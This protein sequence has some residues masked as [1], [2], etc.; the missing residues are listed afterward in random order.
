MMNKKK[1]IISVVFFICYLLVMCGCGKQE[2]DYRQIQVYKIE[3]TAKV[4]RQ[5]SSMDAYENMQ[6][7]SG[8]IIETIAESYLQLKL[9]EDKY[10]L[11][12]PDSKISLQATG[13]SVDSKTSINLE[14]G[15]ITNQLDNPLSKDSSYEVSTPN[16]T[17]AVRGTTFRVELTVD[18]KGETHA[19]VAVYGG[20][21]ECNLVFPDGTIT[22]PVM[23][24]AGTEVLIWGDDVESE[25][26][27]TGNISYGELKELVLDFLEV[28]IDNGEE[29]SITKEEIGKI[30]EGLELLKQE[31]NSGD[32]VDEQEENTEDEKEQ[33]EEEKN[34]E[35]QTIVET[36]KKREPEAAN[37]LTEP[38]Q[39]NP[40]N[41]I[42]FPTLGNNEGNAAN[43]DDIDSGN[44]YYEEE[45]SGS[46][47]EEDNESESPEGGEKENEGSEEGDNGNEGSGGG[48]SESPEGEDNES[49]ILGEGDSGNET[50]GEG[51]DGNE[52]P[53][54]GD[55]GNE[56]PGEGDNGNETPGEGDNGNETPGEGDNGNETP[57]EGD[58]GSEESPEGGDNGSE[59][60][61]EEGDNETPEEGTPEG[62]DSLSKEAKYTI[63]FKVDNN[64]FAEKTGSAL[65]G[66]ELKINKP[67][68]LPSNDSSSYWVKENSSEQVNFDDEKYNIPEEGIL[69]EYIWYTKVQ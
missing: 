51:N 10:I 56:T 16:S 52:T 7:Q 48:E 68:L 25:Y 33:D 2:E 8:D 61:P 27:G 30:K 57:G 35:K 59:E 21:V 19:K 55:D 13:N 14:K 3:G 34:T 44:E 45:N 36:P 41:N 11:V 54:E 24:E 9:D 49:E 31:E 28:I 39:G 53:G 26:V 12:E 20:K 32:E 29:L 40:Q 22:E 60:S 42:T 1:N 4:A 46:Y 62:D 15:A 64:L 17:M 6:L 69:I 37:R 65:V 58:N 47:E 38:L 23:V 63:T 67:I 5:G 50:P 43:E 66:S 18:E